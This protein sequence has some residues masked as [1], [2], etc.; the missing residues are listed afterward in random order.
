MW[1]LTEIQCDGVLRESFCES[2]CSPFVVLYVDSLYSVQV[3]HIAQYDSSIILFL[4]NVDE[5]KY[6][7]ILLSNESS[8][9]KVAADKKMGVSSAVLI[10]V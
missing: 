1:M 4:P 2:C 8:V 10:P 5:K 3:I 9:K 6:T 7:Q